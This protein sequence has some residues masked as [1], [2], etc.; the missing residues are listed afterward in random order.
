M[1]LRDQDYGS[2][3]IGP[4]RGC[5]CPCHTNPG[6]KHIVACCDAPTFDQL[7]WYIRPIPHD[8]EDEAFDRES[9]STGL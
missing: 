4:P 6:T 9:Q 3:L 7:D 8:K 5:G 1:A 2:G